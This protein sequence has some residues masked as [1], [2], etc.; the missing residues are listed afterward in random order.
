MPRQTCFCLERGAL[1]LTF[2]FASCCVTSPLMV[3]FREKEAA[4]F[5]C[6]FF[7][8]TKSNNTCS[9]WLAVTVSTC[10]VC[11]SMTVCH[12][13]HSNI[14]KL[15][16]QYMSNLCQHTHRTSRHHI[17]GGAGAPCH[18]PILIPNDYRTAARCDL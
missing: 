8:I 7:V 11:V 12:T 13:S 9:L 10:A 17:V 4:I 3:H 2:I 6:Y 5:F 1:C 14:H 16:T 18:E 15:F